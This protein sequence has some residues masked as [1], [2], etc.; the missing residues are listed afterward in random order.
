[1]NV[2]CVMDMDPLSLSTEACL[3]NLPERLEPK[4][5]P[6]VSNLLLLHD[7]ARAHKRGPLP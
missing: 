5:T 4:F 1:M 3:R 7:V 6:V 2:L